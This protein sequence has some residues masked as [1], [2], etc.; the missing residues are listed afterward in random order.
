M[1][2]RLL[3]TPKAGAVRGALG[4]VRALLLLD[5]PP[6]DWAAE[7]E[8]PY[9]AAASRALQPS[10]VAAIAGHRRASRPARPRS[11]GGSVLERPQECLCPIGPRQPQLVRSRPS[12]CVLDKRAVGR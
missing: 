9:D 3:H 11:R 6:Y 4:R 7:V 5:P 10:P 12:R 8:W 2:W 1:F